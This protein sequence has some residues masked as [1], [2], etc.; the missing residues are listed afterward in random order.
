[1]AGLSKSTDMTH[2]SIWKHLALF[3]V[4]L[5]LGNLFQ[6]L[7][8]TVDS[9]VLGN[10]VGKSALAAIGCTTFICNTL[11]NFFN[12]I[13][14]GAGI[15]ISTHFGRRDWDKLHETVETAVLTAIVVGALVSLLSVPFVPF[16]LRA[17]STPEETM[18]P[19]SAYL[20]IYFLGTIFLFCY[21]IGSA[22]LRAVGDTRTPLKILILTSILNI[23]MDLL[24][25]VAFQW[26]IAGAA[27]ATVV[28]EAISAF[29]SLA[30]LH[31]SSES[32]RLTW[33]DLRFKPDILKSILLLGMPVG[34]QQALTSFS[35][36]FVQS[37]INSF[38]S[39]SIMAGW[40]VYLKL[41]QFS[42]LPVMS[43]GQATT[44]FVSQNLGAGD[45]GRARKG[46]RTSIVLGSCVVI[47]IALVLGTFAKS[48]V[49][50]F[51]QDPE[52]IYYGTQ[53][54]WMTLPF[55]FFGVWNQTFAGALRGAGD[56]RGPMLI[57]LFSFVFCR[58]AYLFIVTRFVKN[59]YTVGLGY[60]FGWVMCAFLSLFYYCWKQRRFDAQSRP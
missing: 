24:F 3:A 11:V 38:N 14:I 28:S 49:S 27:A 17:I 12:G 60:P 56:T 6:Q 9:I 1:M 20:R 30:V 2:G 48:L 44:T 26:G 22:I 50:L 15:I 58:Q 36:A 19:A 46:T 41:D 59:I 57:M 35:N 21:N 43:I 13:S 5:L 52:V 47:G 29:L 16:M 31:L 54:V 33:Q 7:Y 53:F 42:L 39:T 4:P 10:F 37:Y 55:R 34:I 40:S 51:N 25:V 45:P 18:G 8:N 23:L 32:F